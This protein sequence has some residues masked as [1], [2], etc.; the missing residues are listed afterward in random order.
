MGATLLAA[1]L[2]EAMSCT[3]L[4]LEILSSLRVHDQ[5]VPQRVVLHVQR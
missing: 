1:S 5:V 2:G 3:S 4:T